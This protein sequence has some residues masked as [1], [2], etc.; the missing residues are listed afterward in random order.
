MNSNSKFVTYIKIYLKFEYDS[1]KKSMIDMALC[2]IIFF[3]NL[4]KN[5]NTTK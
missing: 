3:S 2:I 5:K 1:E 4:Y